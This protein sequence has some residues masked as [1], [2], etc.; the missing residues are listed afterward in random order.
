MVN[1]HKYFNIEDGILTNNSNLVK[2]PFLILQN[3]NGDAEKRD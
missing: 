3:T 1:T 2:K